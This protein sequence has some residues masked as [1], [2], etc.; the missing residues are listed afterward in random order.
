MG[1]ASHM[2]TNGVKNRL[3]LPAVGQFRQ[4]LFEQ[5]PGMIPFHNFIPV[6]CAKVA[7]GSSI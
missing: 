5:A 4:A 7:S 2:P 1:I 3:L 6:S